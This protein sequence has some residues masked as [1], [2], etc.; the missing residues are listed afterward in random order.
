MSSE[1]SVVSGAVAL[2]GGSQQPPRLISHR[3]NAVYEVILP[4][5]RAAL[6]LHRPGY[7][8]EAEIRSELQWTEA[9]AERE[10]PAPQPIHM[11]DG[12]LIHTTAD[13]Q[14]VTVIDWMSGAPI[15]DGTL[16]F[17]AST[18]ELAVL[19]HEV[20]GLLARLHNVTDTL[21]LPEGFTRPLW[22]RDGLTGPEPLWGRY[23]QAPGLSEVDRQVISAARDRARAILG[24]FN[25]EA[26]FGLIHSDALRENVFRTGARLAL[27][28]FDDAGVGYRMYELGSCLTQS[29]DESAYPDMVAA[30]LDGYSAIRPLGQR[31]RDLYPMFAMLRAFSAIGWTMPRLFSDDARL[32]KYVRRAMTQATAFLATVDHL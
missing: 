24:D 16:P 27:I 29:V 20:G 2:W 14:F 28:D 30:L 22:D 10:F 26:D 7:R 21:T 3:E 13:G 17:S 25:A 23:W 4:G 6:R 9:L 19:Y 8:T 11:L 31:A 32:P 15:G 18:A 1:E 12:G 5:G